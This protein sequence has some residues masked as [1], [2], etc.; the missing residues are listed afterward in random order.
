MP[1]VCVQD[2]R[3]SKF[4]IK[5][6]NLHKRG[7][8]TGEEVFRENERHFKESHGGSN[9]ALGLLK[10]KTTTKTTTHYALIFAMNY[11]ACN[12]FEIPCK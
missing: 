8:L 6:T 4:M 10:T 12:S 1:H 3:I 2:E 9:E 5:S 11:L 7:L